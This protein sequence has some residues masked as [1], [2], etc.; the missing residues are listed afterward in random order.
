VR[1]SG[2]PT[3]TLDLGMT[4][5]Q[6]LM[7]S[8]YQGLGDL[9]ALMADVGWQNWKAFGTVEVQLVDA[10]NPTSITTHIGYL[11]TWH[12]ALGAQLQFSHAWQL[13][14]GVAYD[15]TMTSDESRSL[16]LAIGD[17]WRFG[18]G[19]QW[20]LDAHWKLSLA[21]EFLWGGSPTVDVE[22]GPTAGRVAGSYADTWLQFISFG[23]T[24]KS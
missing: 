20:T 8:Y 5:P 2:L 16:P 17:E 12:G 18:A 14:L 24:W 15:S 22:R 19:T 23:F 9:L 21:Y 1:L 7:L 11:N 6:T 10:A 13:D 3:Q 4:V